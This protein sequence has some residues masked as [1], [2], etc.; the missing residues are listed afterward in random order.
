MS[1]R[2]RV[3]FHGGLA[4]FAAATALASVFNGYG[5]I[6]P[7]L[8]GVL[9][10][11]VISELVRL[12]PI[13]AAF[14]PILAAAGVLSY[15]TAAYASTNARVGFI[16]S[17]TSLNDLADVAR[18]GFH[19]VHTLATPVPPHRGLVLLAVVGIAAVALVVDL[20][21]VTMRR[22]AL[23]GLP[24]LATFALCTSVS[25]HGVGWVPFAFGTAGYLWLLLADSRERLSRWGRPTGAQTENR[26]RFSWSDTEVTPSPLSVMGRRIGVSA[27]VVAVAVPL[28]IP[29]L[30]GGIPHGG[31]GLGLG[32]GSS[33]RFTVN[34][35]VTISGDLKSDRSRPVLTVRTTDPDPGYLRLTALDRFDGDS[36]AP[37]TLRQPPES[38]V[39][40]GIPILA[41]AGPTRSATVAIGG[42]DVPWLPLPAQVTAVSVSGDWR[43]DPGTDT[44]FSARDSTAG[45]QYNVQ[46]VRPQPS[47]TALEQSPTADATLDRYRALP[48]IPQSVRTLTA[49]VIGK[50][51]TPF[52]KALAIQRFLTSPSFHYDVSVDTG[53]STDALENFLLHTRRG[54]CQ[55]FAAAMAVM[56]RIAGIPSR[57]AVGFTRGVEQPDRAWLITTHDAHAW[58]ELY[59]A[60]YGWLPFEPTPRGDG[61]AQPPAYTIVAT[62]GAAGGHSNPGGSASGGSKGTSGSGLTKNQRL[63]QLSD[64]TGGGA[65]AGN[66]HPASTGS[67]RRTVALVLVILLGI[68]LIAPSIARITLRRRRWRMARTPGARATAAWAELRASAI[69]AQAEWIDGL[70]PRA[71]ARVLQADA[72]GFDRAAIAALQ[73]VVTAVQRAWY[74]RDTDDVA[75]D[76]LEQDVALVSS[77]LFERL[78]SQRRLAARLWP[79]SVLAEARLATGRVGL[80]LD[81]FDL[82]MARLRA[83]LRPRPA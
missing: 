49:T 28:L 53:T 78:P 70:T 6:F 14:G 64:R 2:T 19:D 50:A 33:T 1:G 43:Y 37:S 42:L 10:V 47:P 35:I 5:W 4:T 68:A 75:A 8:G 80:F 48:T 40:R 52:D 20:L 30:R 41:P 73:R 65:G 55:Q 62:P 77:A 44:V 72:L 61:Q 71:T 67:A 27:I 32:G 69:D 38:E 59:F 46:F 57:V 81:R 82:A 39:S 34:P 31:N 58:P 45:L 21:A 18:T 54:F 9:I 26:P 60:G 23:A 76:G 56:A 74:A 83:R 25:K 15:I 7:V 79:R 3:A 11:V 66:D 13:P 12:S 24:L 16:P 51:Q 63:D 22:A 17:G 36:F 29:G